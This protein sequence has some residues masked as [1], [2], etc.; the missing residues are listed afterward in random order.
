MLLSACSGSVKDPEPS[1][2][3][4]DNREDDDD[5]GSVDCADSDCLGIAG[6]VIVAEGEGEGELPRREDDCEDG[7][8]DDGD[9]FVD[10]GDSDCATDVACVVAP[11]GDC[12]APPAGLTVAVMAARFAADIDPLMRRADSG[13]IRCHAAGGRREMQLTGDAAT[14]F[15]QLHA[16]GFL[17][18]DNVDG[19][20]SRILTDSMPKAAPPWSESEKALIK[21]FACD[22]TVTAPA[23]GEGEGDRKSVV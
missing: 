22:L 4:C 8:D 11:V 20:P 1:A 12:A 10:C 21:T 6:C 23:E 16:G 7:S 5:D 14:T 13:C 15:S 3:V 19:A 9:T 2:E 18:L 17:E